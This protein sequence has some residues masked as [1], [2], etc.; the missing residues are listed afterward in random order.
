MWWLGISL[1]DLLAYGQWRTLIAQSH[2]YLGFMWKK[3]TLT[4]IPLGPWCENNLF[5]TRHWETL[6]MVLILSTWSPDTPELNASF[7]EAD[8]MPSSVSSGYLHWLGT[9]F[10][11]SGP[12]HAPST[13]SNKLWCQTRALF[14]PVPQAGKM[15]A[16]ELI[17]YFS[18]LQQHLDS[19]LLCHKIKSLWI[20][21]IKG[22]FR[23][24]LIF[25][26]A[27]VQLLM[28]L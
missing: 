2:I 26:L 8:A 24:F 4:H 11:N 5:W 13:K 19:R 10:G 9:I 18:S 25:R 6:S 16:P 12:Q 22:L 23:V 27:V 15:S 17:C 21:P 20:L 3:S 28:Q 7:N 1:M 14:Q